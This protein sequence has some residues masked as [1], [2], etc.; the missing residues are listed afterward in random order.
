MP[1]TSG[2]SL[3][4]LEGFV[5][6]QRGGGE[7]EDPEK[8]RLSLLEAARFGFDM[9]HGQKRSRLLYKGIMKLGLYEP[10][11]LVEEVLALAELDLT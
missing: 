2:Q 9:G 4:Q 6:R 7:A 11:G 8:L 5:L 10:L 3:R 1:S